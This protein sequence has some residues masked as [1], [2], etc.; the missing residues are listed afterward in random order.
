MQRFLRLTDT[1]K[2]DYGNDQAVCIRGKEH[3]QG[4]R[5]LFSS[6]LSRLICKQTTRKRLKLG[7]KMQAFALASDILPGFVKYEWRW[8]FTMEGKQN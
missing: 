2:C 3:Q 5:V 4:R 7:A 6:I 1:Q 8:E